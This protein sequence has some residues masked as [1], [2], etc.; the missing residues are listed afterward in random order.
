MSVR[1]IQLILEARDR[2]ATATVQNVRG[3]TQGLG[4]DLKS[5][6]SVAAR[7]AGALGL[8]FGAREIAGFFFNTNRE[9]ERLKAQ[10]KTFDGDRATAVFQDIERLA[11][12]TP[13]QIGNLT[14]SYVK[15]RA[16]GINPTEQMMM[17]F[18]DIAAGMSK[19]IVQW[20]EAVADASTGQFE[21]L[22][23]FGIKASS[24]GDQVVLNF[25]GQSIKVRKESQ[26]IVAALQGIGESGFAGAMEDQ[27]D[28]IDG[29]IS[30]TL[31]NFGT[32]ARLIGEGGVNTAIRDV[33]GSVR[34][35]T[36]ELI[37]N[38]D[39]IQA[40]AR[41]AVAA[42][43]FVKEAILLIPRTLKNEVEVWGAYLNIP[44]NA[45]AQMVNFAADKLNWFIEQA[46]RL[47]GVDIDFRFGSVPF[48][49]WEH[50]LPAVADT[51]KGEAADIRS[52]LRSVTD[53]GNTMLARSLDADNTGP[54]RSNQSSG[55]TGLGGG[56]AGIGGLGLAGL[57]G[58]GALSAVNPAL[59]RNSFLPQDL[60]GKGVASSMVEVINQ[61]RAYEEAMA[62]MSASTQA[63]A[64][65]VSQSIDSGVITV[66]QALGP[67][68]LTSL[69]DFSGGLGQIGSSVAGVL[70]DMMINAGTTIVMTSQAFQAFKASLLALT[71]GGGVAA[72][73]ALI[74]A[75]GLMKSATGAFLSNPTGGGSG[76]AGGSL[77]P[78][79][80][81]DLT[82]RPQNEGTIT[83]V[84]PS[85]PSLYDPSDLQQREAITRML[86]S[87]ASG[88]ELKIEVG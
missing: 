50:L 73:L 21:R 34:D 64:A 81:S 87:L 76:G 23:E 3:Q 47:P 67:A 65:S 83:V 56:D 1:S 12:S 54:G 8:V 36:G 71:P 44:F 78:G 45:I 63:F 79:G 41:F 11:S 24:Q 68:I 28:T 80:F 5:L 85:G 59:L 17:S 10:L 51:I 62:R 70:G 6:S 35:F 33:I 60:V 46:N 25:R 55:R 84:F 19:D 75:G 53:A 30:N 86:K 16:I 22:K 2:G 49:E 37:A 69:S 88:R 61:S 39:R 77:S 13:F 20:A 9:T 43:D 14:E 66:F 18:G 57:A 48:V 31:D 72:G 52:A 58:G 26:A 74:V 82:R 38:G 15:L 29:A 32:L 27:M 42:L 7:T 4:T 40:W